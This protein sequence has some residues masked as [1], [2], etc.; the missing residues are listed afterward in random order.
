MAAPRKAV[1]KELFYSIER[2]DTNE[3][4]MIL[5]RFPDL[6]NMAAMN[7]MT[8]IMFA[9]SLGHLQME[10]FWK[11]VAQIFTKK[12]PRTRSAISR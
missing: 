7:D 4:S 6:V 5:K 2:G 3:V 9:S 8:P 1:K 12:S 10:N 11:V